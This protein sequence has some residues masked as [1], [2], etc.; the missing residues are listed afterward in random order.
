MVNADAPDACIKVELLPFKT[1][2]AKRPH[3]LV[4]PA[5]NNTWFEF[6]RSR[7][8]AMWEE[9]R[10]LDFDTFDIETLQH[11]QSQ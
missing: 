8:N 11:R 3:F 5:T 6:F 10:R 1:E 7:C 4:D 9:A 2:S